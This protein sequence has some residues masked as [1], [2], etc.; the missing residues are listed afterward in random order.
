MN[1]IDSIRDVV[2]SM[3]LSVEG[4]ATNDGATTVI[5]CDTTNIATNNIVIIDDVEY[6]ATVENDVLSIEATLTGDVTL[7]IKTPFFMAGF[8]KEISTRLMENDQSTQLYK[9]QKYPLVALIVE[10]VKEERDFSK[11]FKTEINLVIFDTSDNTKNT[12]ERNTEVYVAI[13]EPLYEDL[14]KAFK[15]S[16]VVNV[17]DKK[18]DK[19]NRYPWAKSSIYWSRENILNDPL[20][21]VEIIGLKIK[22]KDC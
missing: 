21:A 14:L 17:Y 6:L 5:L 18:H 20:D 1:V 12:E 16:R 11:D 7:K 10:E 15:K 3:W 9:N 2:E 4:K 13:L 8:P 22:L 19:Y